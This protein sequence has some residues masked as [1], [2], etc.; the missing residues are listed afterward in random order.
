MWKIAN[1]WEGFYFYKD[2][3]C[4]GEDKG[5]RVEVKEIEGISYVPGM[6][7][8]PCLIQ[9]LCEFCWCPCTHESK[10]IQGI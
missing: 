1:C 4:R 3:G 2:A 8:F 9:I 7:T 6:Q 10:K 5:H